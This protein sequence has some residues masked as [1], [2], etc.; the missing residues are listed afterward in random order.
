MQIENKKSSSG[1]N[2]ESPVPVNFDLSAKD[3]AGPYMEKMLKC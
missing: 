2:S 3:M 1:V